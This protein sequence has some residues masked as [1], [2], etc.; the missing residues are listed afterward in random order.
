MNYKRKKKFRTFLLKESLFSGTY[1]PKSNYLR[2]LIK[3]LNILH[4]KIIKKI[5]MTKT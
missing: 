2:N 3:N 1:T 4:W 5:E